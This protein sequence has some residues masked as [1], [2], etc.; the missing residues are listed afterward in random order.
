MIDLRLFSLLMLLV[1]VHNAYAL[2]VRACKG[3]CIIFISLT[4][5]HR[6]WNE[7]YIT[8][9]IIIVHMPHC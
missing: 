7:V 3:F 4:L 2:R 1:L 8:L 9:F 6:M 5:A